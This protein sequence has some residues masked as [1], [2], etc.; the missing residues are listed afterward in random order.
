M[1]FTDS[2]I[3]E[4]TEQIKFLSDEKVL[5]LDEVDTILHNAQ[6]TQNGD[7]VTQHAISQDH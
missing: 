4:I 2:E 7:P 1:S 6:H 3:K 5:T